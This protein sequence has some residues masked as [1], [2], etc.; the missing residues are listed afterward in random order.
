M[1]FKSSDVLK[2]KPRSYDAPTVIKKT[3]SPLGW[4]SGSLCGNV[5]KPVYKVHL[6]E[7]PVDG[8]IQDCG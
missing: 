5:S 8:F 3:D 6:L 4:R 7:K 1:L 2:A